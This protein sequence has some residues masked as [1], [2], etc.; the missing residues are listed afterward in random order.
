MDTR[1]RRLTGDDA[2]WQIY[3]L[4]GT[5]GP[6]PTGEIPSSQIVTLEKQMQF[7]GASMRPL[8]DWPGCFEVINYWRCLKPVAT[9]LQVSVHITDSA[10]QIVAQQ[11]HRP[12]GGWFPTSKWTA[13][14]IVRDRYVLVLPGSLQ[15]G[16]YQIWVGWFDPLR[17]Q[18]LAI[19]TASDNEDRAKIAEIDAR[20]PPGYGWFSPN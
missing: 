18:R 17:R 6:F 19:P 9:D 10:G 16:K 8:T 4:S 20:Q 7:R 12:Q 5:P 11:E 14:D 13:D 3:D 15:G 1:F 2:P